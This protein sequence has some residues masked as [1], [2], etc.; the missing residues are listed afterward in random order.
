MLWNLRV[1]TQV[2]LVP[3]AWSI[4]LLEQAVAKSRSEIA[5]LALGRMPRVDSDHQRRLTSS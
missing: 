1:S 2:P 4:A 5:I 3:A